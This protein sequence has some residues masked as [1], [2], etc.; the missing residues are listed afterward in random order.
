MVDKILPRVF[1]HHAVPTLPLC[2]TTA[3]IPLRGFRQSQNILPRGFRQS[4]NLYNIRQSKSSP[5]GSASLEI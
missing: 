5:A 2:K 4:H 3:N 1:S